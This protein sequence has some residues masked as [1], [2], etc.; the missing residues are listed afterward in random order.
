M[1]DQTKAG[2]PGFN[3]RF[4]RN[5][6]FPSLPGAMEEMLFRSMQVASGDPA[7]DRIRQMLNPPPPPPRDFYADSAEELRENWIKWYPHLYEEKSPGTANPWQ[8]PLG[9]SY[10][11]KYYNYVDSTGVG[12]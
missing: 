10:K 5:D 3:G 12:R 11:G 2:M 6:G 8:T 7:G 4:S 1:F 9:Q